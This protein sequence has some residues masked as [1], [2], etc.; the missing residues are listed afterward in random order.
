MKITSKLN[1][2]QKVMFIY[3]QETR[4]CCTV[5]LYHCFGMV[6]GCLQIPAHGA[7]VVLPSRGFNAGITLKAVEEEKFVNFS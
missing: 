5:P 2:E 6:A 7:T 1:S 3:L 4:L